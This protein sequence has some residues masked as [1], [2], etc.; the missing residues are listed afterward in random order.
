LYTAQLRL[1]QLALERSTDRRKS[2]I[3]AIEQ[4]L[5]KANYFGTPAKPS[6]LLGDDLWER[7]R[8]RLEL[9]VRSSKRQNATAGLDAV[10]V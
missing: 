3:E 6:T 10:Q 1:I 2:L 7:H 4:D 9:F 8:G 5:N